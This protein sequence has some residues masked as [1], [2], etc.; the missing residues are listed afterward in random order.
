MIGYLI[1]GGIF[2]YCALAAWAITDDICDF[3]GSSWSGTVLESL[4][5]WAK[6]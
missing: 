6:K 2:I 3:S 5:R 4:R 1:M